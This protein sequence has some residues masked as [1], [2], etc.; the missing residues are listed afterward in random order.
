[1]EDTGR[2]MERPTPLPQLAAGPSTPAPTPRPWTHDEALAWL[3]AFA[4]LLAMLGATAALRRLALTTRSA[5]WHLVASPEHVA[6]TWLGVLAPRVAVWAEIS[7]VALPSLGMVAL[8]DPAALA[9][10]AHERP[11]EA[12]ATTL[13]EL[14]EAL[15][16]ARAEG[17]MQVR[18]T[19]A[20]PADDEG[21]PPTLAITLS[22]LCLAHALAALETVGD[23]PRPVWAYLREDEDE[24][25]TRVLVLDGA[26]WLAE[27]DEDDQRPLLVGRVAAPWALRLDRVVS[28]IDPRHVGG[29]LVPQL[30]MEAR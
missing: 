2:A 21:A 16:T 22:V 10:L 11:W 7:A 9:S 4:R 20:R 18:V 29:R 15:D 28:T 12:H 26:A 24:D 17:R 1:M 25:E 19:L 3:T 5:D 8:N 23:P 6:G 27:L 13:K 30:A 14:R